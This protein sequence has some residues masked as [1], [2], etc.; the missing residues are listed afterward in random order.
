MCSFLLSTSKHTSNKLEYANELQ[1]RRGPDATHI[2]RHNNITFLHNLLSITGSFAPQPFVDQDCIAIFNGEIYNFKDL[3]PESKSDGDCIIPAYKKYGELFLKQ[4]DGEFAVALIDIKQNLLIFGVDTFGCKPLNFSFDSEGYHLA[5]YHSAL[6]RLDCKHITQV[7]GNEW[8]VY[9][10]KRKK[11]H[12]HALTTF[13]IDNEHKT[14][15]N[16]WN[17]AFENSIKKR[18]IASK[19]IMMGLSEG[20]DSGTICSSLIKHN[21]DFKAYSVNVLEPPSNVLLWRHGITNKELPIINGVQTEIPKIPHKQLYNPTLTEHLKVCS[22]IYSS[23]EEYE[24]EWMNHNTNK[25]QRTVS[26]DTYGF[27]GA[28][29][30]FPEAYR[31]GYRICLSGCAGDIIGCKDINQKMRDLQNINYLVDYYD[32]NVYSC[33]YSTGIYGLEVRYPYLDTKLWQETFWIDKNIHKH[34]KSPQRQYMLQNKFPF[35]DIDQEG[36]EIFE[37]VGFFKKMPELFLK[38]RQHLKKLT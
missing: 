30:F 3:N 22:Q 28:G 32:N 15:F 21:I 25:L 9:D 6:K 17:V 5:S 20:Y 7:N 16:D 8:Y 1:K 13:D 27:T 31:D 14:N 23:C 33:E 38:Y 4:L 37:Y 36:K 26:R 11:L 29:F 10:I 34:W 2:S 19:P 24:Y 12:K 35:V 18:A